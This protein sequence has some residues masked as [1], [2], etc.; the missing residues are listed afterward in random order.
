M[1]FY[2][3]YPLPFP[4]SLKNKLFI[5]TAHKV[6]I[7]EVKKRVRFRALVTIQQKLYNTVNQLRI[8]GVKN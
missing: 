3:S 6:L 1:I 5:Y 4:S 7:Y 2:F 8:P